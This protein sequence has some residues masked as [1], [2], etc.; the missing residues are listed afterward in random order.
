MNSLHDNLH[1]LLAL[2]EALRS[3][4]RPAG[5]VEVTTCARIEGV[6]L[7]LSMKLTVRASGGGG[8]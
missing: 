6:T 8:L 4:D 2:S 5:R 3:L 1:W 7:Q